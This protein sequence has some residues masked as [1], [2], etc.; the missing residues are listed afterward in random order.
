M[1]PRKKQYTDKQ[2]AAYYKKLALS[3]AP[4][5]RR[6]VRSKPRR[7]VARGKGAYQV[8]EKDSYGTQLGGR[9]GSYIGEGLGN[10][11]Q[12][13]LVSL[14][15]NSITGFGDYQVKSNVLLAPEPPIMINDSV[16]GGVLIRHREFLQD[17]ITSSTIG[18]FNLDSFPVN[19]A[20]ERT[21]PFLSQ[22]AANYEQYS[23]EGCIFEFRS[24][25]ADALNSTNT[26]LG[27]VIMASNYDSLDINF[28]SK[29]EMENYEFGMS[30]KPSCNMMHPIECAPRQTTITE[31]YTRNGSA[32]AN[33]DLR[34]YDWCNTQ[35]ATVGFQAASV[36]IGE[37]WVTYQ[38][39]LLKPKLFASLGEFNNVAK[40]TRSDWTNAL[41]LGNLSSQTI[42][43]NSLGITLGGTQMFLPISGSPQSYYV[44]VSWLSAAAGV[45][46]VYPALTFLNCANTTYGAGT[47]PGSDQIPVG[48]V[49]TQRAELSFSI[50]T[51]PQY[52]PIV[53]FGAA[54]TLPTIAGNVWIRVMQ[55]PNSASNT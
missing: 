50:T 25:S 27:S 30:C 29:S 13:A 38:V 18:A 42:Y 28:T 51:V 7:R 26:A 37:L 4:P 35:I 12:N 20:M 6:A 21:F 54:G 44:R 40:I 41:P 16:R 47:T 19:A 15:G 33:S 39:R 2:K 23:L 32:P 49:V 14:V 3:G 1:P 55:I 9:I 8:D 53:Q 24:M 43:S 48:G 34:L 5:K 11:A 31:L 36:N 17:I 45:A 22:I 52:T 46:V 10:L